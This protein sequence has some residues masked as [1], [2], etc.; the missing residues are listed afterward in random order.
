MGYGNELLDYGRI[1]SWGFKNFAQKL[2]PD[3]TWQDD[4]IELVI[5]EKKD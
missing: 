3:L 1:N 5:K 4:P 2:V